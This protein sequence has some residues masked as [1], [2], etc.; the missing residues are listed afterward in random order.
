M[1]GASFAGIQ[2]LA[3]VKLLD[4]DFVRIW[5]QHIDKTTL[6]NPWCMVTWRGKQNNYDPVDTS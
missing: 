6:V 4:E 3:E 5:R 1:D 2:G